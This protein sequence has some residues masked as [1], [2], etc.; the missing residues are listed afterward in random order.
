MKV[1]ILASLAAA[2][3]LSAPASAQAWKKCIPNSI[4]PGGC[5]SIAP[6]LASRSHGEADSRQR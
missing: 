1:I 3:L 5:D 2:C 6:V 4:A